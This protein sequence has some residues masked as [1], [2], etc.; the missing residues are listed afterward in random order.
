VVE[1]RDATRPER[2]TGRLVKMQVQVGDVGV[3]A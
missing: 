3:S 1:A 2:Q